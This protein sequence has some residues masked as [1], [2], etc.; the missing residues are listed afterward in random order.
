MVFQ[1]RADDILAFDL[2]ARAELPISEKLV[3]IAHQIAQ[4][5]DLVDRLVDQRAAA[6]DSPTALDGPRI[7]LLRAPPFN[8]GV[9]LQNAAQTPSGDGFFHEHRGVVEAVLAGHAEHDRSRVGGGDDLAR[10]V[11]IGGDGLLQLD[12]FVVA[13]RGLDGLQ[14]EVGEGAD[15]DEIDIRAAAQILIRRHELAAP[16]RGELLA[17]LAGNIVAGGD[18]VAD[19]AVRAGVHVRDG[20]RADDAD[21]H[22][23]LSVYRSRPENPRRAAYSRPWLAPQKETSMPNSRNM[24]ALAARAL[25]A[26]SA[27]GA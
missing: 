19:I 20:A 8:V 23:V 25:S 22:G 10:G 13:G 12:V 15:V 2:M 7:I 1:E 11:E 6:F 18:A 3:D 27:E 9:G 14:A 4:H 26:A 5:V 16:E 24:A 21:S 17:G